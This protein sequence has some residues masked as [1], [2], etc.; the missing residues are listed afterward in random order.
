MTDLEVEVI[1][2]L[3]Y[4]R[5]LKSMAI[6]RGARFGVNQN[7]V[8]GLSFAVY[9]ADDVGCP[10]FLPVRSAVAALQMYDVG[11]VAN[12]DG[13]PCWVKIEDGIC[14]FDSPCLI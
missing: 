9:I 12:L 4:V 2:R 13:K 11:S 1:K 8:V 14:T 5:P 6:I 3:S 7:G 10:Q